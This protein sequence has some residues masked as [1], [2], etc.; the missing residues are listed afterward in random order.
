MRLQR[1][2]TEG[3]GEHISGVIMFE[4]MIVE[5]TSSGKPFTEVLKERGVL[6]GIKVDQGLKPLPGTTTDEKGTAGTRNP[7]HNRWPEIL[8]IS[9]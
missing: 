6:I 4:G 2:T 7:E 1:Y 5:K 3:L 9:T 8:A